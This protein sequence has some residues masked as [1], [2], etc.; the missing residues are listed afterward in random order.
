M[1][2]FGNREAH[3]YADRIRER[4]P[5]RRSRRDMRDMIAFRPF[6]LGVSADEPELVGYAWGQRAES[7]ADENDPFEF[8][9]LLKPGEKTVELSIEAVN[10]AGQ[11]QH[12][13][14]IHL[15]TP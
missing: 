13:A 10:A 7:L 4:L 6:A 1:P 9:L 14:P 11:P 3:D 2:L 15:G 8:T 12:A 5:R